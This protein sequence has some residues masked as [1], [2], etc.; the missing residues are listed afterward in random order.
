[1]VEQEKLQRPTLRR[2]TTKEQKGYKQNLAFRHRA[3][4]AV[5]RAQEARARLEGKRFACRALSGESS[6]NI[7]INADL[8][9]S[10]NCDDTY[11]EGRLGSLHDGTFEEIFSGPVATRFR[12]TLARG[13]IP[14]PKCTTCPELMRVEPSEAERRVD[15]YALPTKGLLFENNANCNLSCVGCGRAERPLSSLKMRIEDVRDVSRQLARIGVDRIHYFS[16]GEPFMSR[17]ILEEM[18][19]IREEHPSA[20]I[21]TSTN[22]A[23]VDTDDKRLAALMMDNVVFSVDGCS[24]ETL[25]RY[26]VGANFAKAYENMCRLVEMRD[27]LRAEG[28]AVARITWKY[29]V[30]RWNDRAEHVETTLELARRANVDALEFVFTL[31]P[32]WG[33]SPRFYVAPHWRKLGP[34]KHKRR[35][36]ELR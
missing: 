12:E 8:S 32:Y 24:Q 3:M 15:T 33:I 10:C 13:K 22:G 11:G 14:I 29:V 30:F 27:K 36:L 21:F 17:N 7:C 5:A 28:R 31:N 6:Y 19:V 34:A 20:E 35:I 1:M 18:K 4:V 25:V 2:M 16:L 26:Q 9:V 23:L